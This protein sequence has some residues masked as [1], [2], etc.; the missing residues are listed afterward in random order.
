MLHESTDRAEMIMKFI[1][2]LMHTATQI[3]VIKIAY[4]Y[5]SKDVGS[6]LKETNWQA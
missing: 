2:I 5:F 4:L 3:Y 6:K 1:H